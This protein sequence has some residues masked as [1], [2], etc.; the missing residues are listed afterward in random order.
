MIEAKIKPAI[1]TAPQEEDWK[2]RTLADLIRHI[3]AAHHEYL[4]EELPALETL[5]MHSAKN[6]GEP[7]AGSIAGLPRIFRQFRR[8]ME[9]HMKREEAILFPIIERLEAERAAGREAPRLPFGSIGRP[10]DVMEQEHDRARKELAEI[11][12]LTSDYTMIPTLTE[13]QPSTLERLKAVDGDMEI[14]SRLE[15]EILFPRAIALERV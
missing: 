7:T 13:A 1:R 4:R 8:G 5:L 6:G 9:E 15:D 10:I 12:T 14:H 3:I 11:R 2:S